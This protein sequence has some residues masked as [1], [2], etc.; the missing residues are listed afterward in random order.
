MKYSDGFKQAAIEKLL[1]P[2]CPGLKPLARDLGVSYG[3]LRNWRNQI[4]G[5]EVKQV[6]KKRPQD[7]S[8]EEKY[9]AV[10]ETASLNAEEKSAYCRRN[11][12]FERDLELWKEQ[13]LA[14]MRKGPKV[15]VEKKHM[16]AEIKE[17]K[18]DLNRKDKALAE[19]TALLVLQ[20]KAKI[21][22]GH[23]EDEDS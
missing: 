22:F 16:K 6:G 23:S 18:R 20:K 14:G 10:L 19:T 15:D 7:W 17:L 21:L 2:N 5:I 11:G 12:L 9:Q 13:C 4:S 3:T 8:A 1:A